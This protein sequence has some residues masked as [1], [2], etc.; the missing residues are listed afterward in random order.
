MKKILTI[1]FISLVLAAASFFF[2]QRN[3]LNQ[4]KTPPISVQ[5]SSIDFKTIQLSEYFEHPKANLVITNEADWQNLW[6][7]LFK[8][9]EPAPMPPEIDFSK[10]NV[11]AVFAGQK[12]NGG[13]Q[14][15]I[16]SIASVGNTLTVTV[17]Q[18][19]PGPNCIV[20]ENI[21]FPGQIVTIPK[22]NT[23]VKFVEKSVTTNCR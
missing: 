12:S 4:T 1:V 19:S 11:I 5:P 18:T 2:W 21:T 14:I 10:N 15:E 20:T 16:T 17:K 13:Y 22:T 6:N 23:K 7:E 3:Q 8:K 9:Q